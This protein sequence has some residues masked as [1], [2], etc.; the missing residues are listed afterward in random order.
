MRLPLP[1]SQLR[2]SSLCWAL[3]RGGADLELAAQ[4]G[5]GLPELIVKGYVGGAR[6]EKPAGEG[7]ALAPDRGWPLAGPYIDFLP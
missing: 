4:Q 7:L 2:C 5:S 6:F 1:E 3:S